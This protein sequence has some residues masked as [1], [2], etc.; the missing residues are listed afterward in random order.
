MGSSHKFP[1]RILKIDR[2]KC[3]ALGSLKEMYWCYVYVRISTLDQYE[4]F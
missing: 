3:V 2:F 1:A 4:T